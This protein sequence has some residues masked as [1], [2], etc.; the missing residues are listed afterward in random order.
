FANSSNVHHLERPTAEV[1][2]GGTLPM[3]LTCT[4]CHDPHGNGNYRNLRPDPTKT[5]LA[6]I[7][8]LTQQLVKANGSNPSQVYVP[9]NLTYKSG[10]SRWCMQCH[11]ALA[12]HSV[13]KTMWDATLAD[14]P[15]WSAVAIARVPV[16]SADNAI[17]SQD[18]RVICLSCHKAHGSANAHAL[19]YADGVTQESTCEECHDQ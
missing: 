18:D 11:T 3:V 2:P 12:H 13:D 16:E 17:P 7:T 19:I 6:P 14:Y 9:S 15:T 8:V 5:T 10:M 1:P 4:T